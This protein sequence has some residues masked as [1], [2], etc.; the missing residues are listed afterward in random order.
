MQAKHR[1]AAEAKGQ[2][3]VLGEAPE[4]VRVSADGDYLQEVLDNL[5]T[6]ALK[7]MAPGP[8][9]R[10]ATLGFGRLGAMGFIDIRDEGP[11]FSEEDRARAFARFTK[12]SARPTGGET[13]TGLGLSIVRKLVERMQGRV[14]LDSQLGRGS[15]FRLSFPLAEEA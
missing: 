13:S 15:R 6:N 8:P 9:V 11:G 10:T 1:G 5:V 14:E 2:A 7:F 12:L 4:D 3:L